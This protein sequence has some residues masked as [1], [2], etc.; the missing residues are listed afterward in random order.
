[1]RLKTP[2]AETG[3]LLLV[4]TGLMLASYPRIHLGL[5]NLVSHNLAAW[6]ARSDTIS[7]ILLGYGVLLL[8]MALLSYLLW[9]RDRSFLAEALSQGRGALRE[10][11]H[12]L[13]DPL[14]DSPLTRSDAIFLLAIVMIGLVARAYFLAQPMR[15]DEAYTFIDFVQQS[16]SQSFYYLAPNNHVLHTLLVKITTWLWGASPAALRL[17]AL[18]SGMVAIPL[19][20]LLSRKLHRGRAGLLAAIGMAV[21][22]YLILYGTMARGYTLLVCLT[23]ALALVG[24]RFVAEPGLPGCMLISLFAALGMLTIPTMLYAIAGLYL[25]IALIITV[26]GGVARA[27]T[28]FV[29]PCAVLT[30]AFTFI[31]YTPVMLMSGGLA[32]ITSN[33]FVMPAPWDDFLNGILPHF[34]SVFGDFLRDVSGPTLLG[35][36]ALMLVG[37]FA[38]ARKRQWATLL[39]FACVLL[40][41]GTVFLVQHRI[42]FARTWIYLIPFALVLAD[43]GFATVLGKLGRR[44]QGWLITAVIVLGG[45]FAITLMTGNTIATYADTGAFPEAA[46][47]ARYLKPV[48]ASSDRVSV[49]PLAD[50][51]S[52]YYFW[53]YGLPFK[54]GTASDA[55]GNHYVIVKTN[56]FDICDVANGP[57]RLLFELDHAQVFRYVLPG[58]KISPTRVCRIM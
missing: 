42:P 21:T 13:H 58:E 52:R 32:A 49:R 40:G 17:P 46:A 18:A 14:R 36:F 28:G 26:K 16:F 2:R 24:A 7:V 9:L 35:L 27:L 23:I 31:A 25:W 1:M 30:G 45:S 5:L 34:I 10:L 20:F 44:L 55:G 39:L 47:V 50:M 48:I 12:S 51:P 54:A 3:F 33:R 11:K 4:A 6:E 19:A 38:A 57:V 29:V 15:F 22:P 37:I 53:Y 56:Q 8:G 43:G 41:S